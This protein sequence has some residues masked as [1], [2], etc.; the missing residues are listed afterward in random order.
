MSNPLIKSVFR[1]LYPNEEIAGTGFLLSQTCG[2]TCAHVVQSIGKKPGDELQIQFHLDDT[3]YSVRIDESGWLSDEDG[4][5]AVLKFSSALP[6]EKTPVALGKSEESFGN[7]YLALG[8]PDFGIIEARWPRGKIGGSIRVKGKDYIDIQG[9]EIKKGISGA[10]VYDLKNKRVIGMISFYKDEHQIPNRFSYAIPSETLASVISGLR[11]WP[12]SYGPEEWRNY[13][14]YLVSINGQLSLPDSRKVPLEK[15]Y[16]SLRADEMNAAERKAEYDLYI[17][18][19]ERLQNE[20]GNSG[21]DRYVEH[22][23]IWKALILQPKMQMLYSREWEPQFTVRRGEKI[24]L[25]EVVQ[26]HPCVVLLGDPGSGK[27]TLGRWLTLQQS[28]ALVASKDVL[29][30]PFDLVQPGRVSEVSQSFLEGQEETRRD[31]DKSQEA[32]PL[33]VR[34]L[35]LPPPSSLPSRSQIADSEILQESAATQIPPR[36]ARGIDLGPPKLTI[37][38]K[39]IKYARARWQNN[40]PDNGLDLFDFIATGQFNDNIL[41]SHLSSVSVGALCCD[42]LLQ[43]NAFAIF[44]GLDEVG[45]PDQRRAVMQSI[46]EFI[47]KYYKKGNRILLT[48]RIVGYQFQPL[49]HLPHYTV[50][51]MDETAIKAFCKAWMMHFHTSD[52]AGKNG[53]RLAD[54]ILQYGH[55][56]VR[57]LAGNPLMLTLLAQVYRE[58]GTQELPHRRV[59]LFDE[60]LSVFY[61]Q[62][63]HLWDTKRIEEHHLARALGAVAYELHNSEHSDFIDRGTVV[64]SLLSSLPHPDQAEEVL[65]VADEAAGFLV[66]RGEG[67]YGFLHRALQ[68]YFVSLYLTSRPEKVSQHL[69]DHALDPTWREPL[70]MALGKISQSGRKCYPV[71]NQIGFVQKVWQD[72]LNSPDP[73]GD[74]LPRR[75]LLLATAVGEC[76]QFPQVPL[77]YVVEQLLAVYSRRL[78]PVLQDRIRRAF[79]SIKSSPAESMVETALCD[80]LCSPNIDHRWAAADLIIETQW[81]SVSIVKALLR[82][83]CSFSEPAG[84]LLIA[85]NTIHNR[86][87][88]FFKDDFMPFRASMKNDTD[89]WSSV[90]SDDSWRIV[91]EALYMHPGQQVE[92]NNIWRESSLTQDFLAHIQKG[93]TLDDWLPELRLLSSSIHTTKGRDAALILAGIGEITPEVYETIRN[94]NMSFPYGFI[95]SARFLVGFASKMMVARNQVLASAKI[96]SQNMDLRNS[97]SRSRTMSHFLGFKGSTARDLTVVIQKGVSVLNKNRLI[98]LA[99][100]ISLALGYEAGVDEVADDETI[101]DVL[102]TRAKTVVERQLRNIIGP[103]NLFYIL[104]SL[105][106]PFDIIPDLN[107]DEHHTVRILDFSQEFEVKHLQDY[108]EYIEELDANIHEVLQSKD[109]DPDALHQLEMCLEILDTLRKKWTSG[110]IQAGDLLEHLIQTSRIV[111]RIQKASVLQITLAK[112]SPEELVSSLSHADDSHRYAI[113]QE[114]SR[115]FIATH[116]GRSCLEMMAKVRIEYAEQY[117]ISTPLDWALSNVTFDCIDWV[118]DWINLSANS[119]QDTIESAILQNMHHSSSEV[120]KGLIALFPHNSQK[121]NRIILHSIRWQ[122]YLKTIPEDVQPLVFEKLQFWLS[123]EE[124]PE[125]LKSILR[126]F[127]AWHIDPTAALRFILNW[128]PSDNIQPDW[129]ITLARLGYMSEDQG[130]RENIQKQLISHIDKSSIAASSL[131]RFM[132][133]ETDN[134]LTRVHAFILDEEQ[135]FRAFLSAGTDSDPWEDNYHKVLVTTIQDLSSQYPER[136]LPVLLGELREALTLEDDDGWPRR[137]ITLAA[138]AACIEIMPTEMQRVAGG[139][140]ALEKLLIEGSKDPRSFNARRFAIHALGYLRV[141]TP[142]V[143]PV[144]ISGLQD[145]TGTVQNNTLDSVA[146]FQRFQGDMLDEL[147]S[148]LIIENSPATVYGIA[149]L[150]GALGISSAAEIASIRPGIIQG[151]ADAIRHPNSQKEVFLIRDSS[152]STFEVISQ[153]KLFDHLAQEMLRVAGWL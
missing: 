25:A 21:V 44:D 65:R 117:Q 42:T 120:V 28:R 72:I 3:K 75:A 54:S 113:I 10:P 84:G 104:S 11:L 40:E 18:D 60:T 118:N 145:N 135:L 23:L 107:N 121:V 101:R 20:L 128:V 153:G 67:I 102:F 149:K 141:I 82:A 70:V 14:D 31:A 4:D 100:A 152:F 138:V 2:V 56:G 73:A 87:P 137:R 146:H 89:G 76:A 111:S 81:E 69:C 19:R 108:L 85:L 43:G 133:K 34:P 29:L 144:L 50:E 92:L 148:Y 136:L 78:A 77:S 105:S 139:P 55:P 46:N 59:D 64:A 1:I 37:F 8:Y 91:V 131:A 32:N 12:N 114:L 97:R 86:H 134:Y 16:V 147:L 150:L 98:S 58:S 52:N 53:E 51:E 122:A 33:V 93:H 116:L 38:L 142:S 126:V 5:I 115:P 151:L 57:A 6:E 119:E 143:V 47:D 88:E 96:I 22:K 110:W 74:V 17:Q 49:T 94:E 7:D 83:W 129:F 132:L 95:A 140:Q 79:N 80:Y 61:K 9:A 63:Q 35:D 39:I 48:S 26:R 106:S 123:K 125:I 27:T 130:L 24:N 90:E 112:I 30:V 62:R 15:I 45:D 127:G 99:Q 103:E 66:S 109:I 124:H 41:P 68:E 13:L 36:N 71:P